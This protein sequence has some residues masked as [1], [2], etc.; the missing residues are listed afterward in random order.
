MAITKGNGFPARLQP[1]HHCFIS[2]PRSV[3]LR[4]LHPP[5]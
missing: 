4:V 1:A 2:I 3:L 5:P